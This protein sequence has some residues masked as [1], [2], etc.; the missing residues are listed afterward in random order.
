MGA[1]LARTKRNAAAISPRT[2]YNSI[3]PMIQTKC[4]ATIGI[5]ANIAANT[6]KFL[7]DYAK[8][9]KIFAIPY[10]KIN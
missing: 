3:A 7:I 6:E 8:K 5:A 1:K 2:I 9:I 10:D 4:G